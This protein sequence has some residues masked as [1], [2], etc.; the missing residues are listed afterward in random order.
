MGHTVHKSYQAVDQYPS[1]WDHKQQNLT[2][3]TVYRQWSLNVSVSSSL[4]PDEP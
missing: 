2:P 3:T 4:I 1:A